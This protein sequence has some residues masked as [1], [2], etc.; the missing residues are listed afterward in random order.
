[1][2]GIYA[3]RLSATH[4]RLCRTPRSHPSLGWIGY[5]VLEG[6]PDQAALRRLHERLIGLRPKE[7]IA[8]L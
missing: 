8:K 2:R 1:M 3:A 6:T 5:P 4:A 7:Y